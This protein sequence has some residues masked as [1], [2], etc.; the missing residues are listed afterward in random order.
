MDGGGV[1]PTTIERGGEE[2][3]MGNL[4]REGRE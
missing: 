4:N 1:V 3:G 2:E